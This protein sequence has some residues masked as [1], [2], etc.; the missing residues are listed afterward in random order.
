VVFLSLKTVAFRNLV[1]S[2]TNL[3]CKNTVLV[4]ENGQGKSNF[5]EA[6]YFC[7]YASSFRGVRDTE[8]SLHSKKDF[9]VMAETD[10]YICKNLSVIFKDGKKNIFFDKKKINDRKELLEI[11]P[12]IIVCHEDLDFVS[13]P[14][15][16]RRWFF[17][18]TQSLVDSLYLD[19]LRNYRKILKSRNVVLK[20]WK[21]RDSTVLLDAYDPQ[22]VHYGLRLMEKRT[23]MAKDFSSVFE[24]LYHEI[25][26]ID[27]VSIQYSPSWKNDNQDIEL[28]SFFERREKDIAYGMSLTGPHRDNYIFTR[29]GREFTRNAST[30]QRRLLALLLR[31]AQ[32]KVFSGISGKAVLTAIIARPA[33]SA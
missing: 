19:D 27:G 12:S 3:K 24:P 21:G 16:R 14:P 26:G 22:M 32:V 2:E 17:D 15:E 31:M 28:S 23:E 4:G 1:D 11:V 20:S 5:I 8:L 25:S 33:F 13:G 18:Q 30:G 10:N 7:S 6:L 29:K 9:S